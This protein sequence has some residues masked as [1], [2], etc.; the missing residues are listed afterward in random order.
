VSPADPYPPPLSSDSSP[1]ELLAHLLSEA[2]E[3]LQRGEPLDVQTFLPGRPDLWEQAALLLANL[4]TF[5]QK[6]QQQVA[7]N[8]LLPNPFPGK[9]RFLRLLGEGGFGKVWLAE[10]LDLGRKVALK[11]VRLP[12]ADEGGE[13]AL[14]ALKQEARTL[15]AIQ[16]RY[17]HPN[18]VGVFQWRE[19][20]GQ[21]YL[22]M[23]YV[24]GGALDRLVREQGPL[25][26]EHAA[27]YIADVGEGLAVVH[28]A[29]IIH[30]DIKPGNILLQPGPDDPEEK[31][32]VLTDFGIS[33]RL[34][35]ARTITGTKSYMAPEAFRGKFAEASDVY[36]LT[37]SLFTLVS[38]GPP[39]R[40]SG[41][42]EQIDQIKQGLPH[43]E[44]RLFGVPAAIEQVIR[45]GLAH[46]PEQRPTLA[47]FIAQL[48]GALNQ[49]LADDLARIVG[50]TQTP[51]L[52]D[53]RLVVDRLGP[54][55]REPVASTF[56]LDKQGPS[57]DIKTVPPAPQQV[58]VHTGDHIEV[59]VHANQ[60]GYLSVWNVGPTGNLSRLHPRQGPSPGQVADVAPARPLRVLHGQLAPP[61]G[62]ERLIAFWSQQP[63]DLD[64][65]ELCKLSGAQQATSRS[66]Q[67]SRSI[68]RMRGQMRQAHPGAVHTAILELD[69]VPPE[70]L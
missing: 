70:A 51:A 12:D 65:E 55:G 41:W 39:F 68:A 14:E 29:G 49:S 37:A 52:V 5:G 26:W 66:Y 35:D 57:R 24:P 16:D 22:V 15:V 25:P 21:H 53:L 42:D 60:E 2:Q 13:K 40:G 44:P 10:D 33:T 31:E 28:R 1:Q 64:L 48:R 4:S 61:A 54:R 43:P 9:F 62:R 56:R 8:P 69:H 34:A 20:A 30:R 27:R 47:S 3:R 63:L 18:I 6:N 11:T 19:A 32:A 67:A 38:G 45:A 36:S 59:T 58:R 46:D 23:Q 7:V 17:R 50:A